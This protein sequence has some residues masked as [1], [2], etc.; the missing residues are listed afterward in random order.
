M[1]LMR[2]RNPDKTTGYILL[3][4]TRGLIFLLLSLSLQH[5]VKLSRGLNH[6]ILLDTRHQDPL[7]LLQQQGLPVPL[8]FPGGCSTWR[9]WR[10]GVGRASMQREEVL[11]GET[12][13]ADLTD[14]DGSTLLL[15]PIPEIIRILRT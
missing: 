15:I 1:K 3:P 13:V 10:G 14:E 5:V 2:I 9:K 11:V 4:V 8:P 12:V 7:L 6:N